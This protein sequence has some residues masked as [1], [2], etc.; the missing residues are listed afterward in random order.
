[1]SKVILYIAISVDGYIADKEG[2]VSWLDAFGDCDCGYTD[3][4]DSVGSLIMGAKTYEQI[5]S[6]DIDWPYKEKKS[7]ILTHRNLEKHPSGDIE[8]CDDDIESIISKAKESA[9]EKNVWL[10]GGTNVVTS[11][12]N[13]GAIDE[14][15][16]FVIPTLLNE[17]IPLF[18]EV[19]SVQSLKLHE[20]TS[21]DNGIVLLHYSNK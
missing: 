4:M 11:F 20:T 16:I 5:L 8:F 19:A 2:G 1:M 9:K 6:F 14:M 18:K 10:V 17:G 12:L 7:Y 15:M 3:F 21:Y 13:A